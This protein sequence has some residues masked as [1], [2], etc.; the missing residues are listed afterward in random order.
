[1]TKLLKY[2]IAAFL[3]I[4][5]LCLANSGMMMIAGGGVPVAAEGD[6]D[7]WPDDPTGS[8]Y[9]YVDTDYAGGSSDGSESDP[10]TTLALAET[11]IGT[12]GNCPD[13]G[14]D[15]CVIVVSASSGT[16]DTSTVDIYGFANPTAS[17]PLI[18]R[19]AE[20]DRHDGVWSNSIYRLLSTGHGVDIW[21]NYVTI[22]GLQIEPG[23]SS[24]GV[25][26]NHMESHHATVDSCIIRDALIGVK[27]GTGAS[28]G[29]SGH[30]IANNIIYDSYEIGII[31][32][33]G[34][35]VWTYKNY[36]INNTVYLS[37]LNNSATKGGISCGGGGTQNV[38]KNNIVI[39]HGTSGDA[40]YDCGSADE[41]YNLVDDTS[42][43]T[44]ALR[45]KTLADVDFVSTTAGSEDLQIEATSDAV[46]A[47]TDLSSITVS[48]DSFAW[49][50]ENDSRATSWDIGADEL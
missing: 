9:I 30:I 17:A 39:D 15:P 41:S 18:I 45:S 6:T 8:E 33:L 34:T 23:A 42:G 50:M 14:T 26:I 22:R 38:V 21:E 13:V 24:T 49:D 43:S 37:N 32:S 4:P 5:S 35:T 11:A 28:A 27:N 47:G 25:V 12:T 10:W 29:Y 3:L 40:L 16:A 20:S 48:G 1:M 19:P 2:I 46:D 7:S 44:V 36:I 31:A